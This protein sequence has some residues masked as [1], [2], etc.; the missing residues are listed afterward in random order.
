MSA[1]YNH[2]LFQQEVFFDELE[3]GQ[4]FPAF[5]YLLT[6]EHIDAYLRSV[7][8]PSPII[9]DENAARGADLDGVVVPSLVALNYGFVY[10]A[11]GRRP[12]TGF[13][14]SSVRFEFISPV[15]AVAELIMNVSVAAKE[16]KRDRKYVVLKADV[17]NLA[18]APLCSAN[19]SC[20][21]P[22]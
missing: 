16:V 5:H 3:V 17:R 12:P 1:L 15:P 4:T 13:L 2:K 14:N 19:I 6:P 20:V 9:P 8:E 22:A 21:F 7:D 10:S 18:G 11:M